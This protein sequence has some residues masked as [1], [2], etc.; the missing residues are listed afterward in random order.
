MGLHDPFGH[1]K[2]KLWPKERL[3]VKLA[4]WFVTTK[5]RESTLFSHVKVA[6]DILAERSLQGLQLCFRPHCNQ[7]ASRKVMGPKVARVLARGIPGL[8]LGCPK[9]NAIWMWPPWRGTKYIIK[10][11]VVASP[12]FGPWWVLWVW[13]CSWLVLA[14]KVLKLCTNQHVMWFL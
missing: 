11:K 3:R 5:S 14:P 13:V 1:L 8:P 2:D 10:G 12:K 9:Q 7:R 4:I 6:C